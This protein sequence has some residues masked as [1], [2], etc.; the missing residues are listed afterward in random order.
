MYSP[1]VIFSNNNNRKHFSLAVYLQPHSIKLIKKIRLSRLRL[2]KTQNNLQITSMRASSHDSRFP[3]EGRLETS[4]GEVCRESG[5]NQCQ[6]S[7][8]PLFVA[9]GFILSRKWRNALTEEIIMRA[10]R[11]LTKHDSVRYHSSWW[12]AWP[13][14]SWSVTLQTIIIACTFSIILI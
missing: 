6:T 4:Q 7:C 13:G 12:R 2:R 5:T 14:E 10:A 11:W 9:Q 8:R 3:P 1:D